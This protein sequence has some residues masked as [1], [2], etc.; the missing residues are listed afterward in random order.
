MIM[1]KFLYSALL[2]ALMTMGTG[3]SAQNRH[4]DWKEKMMSEKIAFMTMELD[5]TPKEAQDFW[6]VYNKLGQQLDEARHE[7]MK[8]RKDLKEAL[9]A[10]KSSKEISELLDRYMEAKE[11]QD[12][13]DNSSA[14]AYKK[15][16]PVEKVAKL[17][18]A[19][20]KFRRQFINKLQHKK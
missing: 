5:I 12:K 15:V 20:E 3:A 2:C 6:P 10:G 19:E 7:I 14:E 16:L 4:E 9:D 8:A 18:I 13:L 1:K 17:Y 11:N